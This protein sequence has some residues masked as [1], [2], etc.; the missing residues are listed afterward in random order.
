MRRFL[1]L[2]LAI[3]LIVAGGAYAGY[4]VY[5]ADMVR[6]GIDDWIAE[7]RARGLDIR[8]TNLDVGGFPLR[9]EAGAR[10]ITL[11]DGNR[12]VWQSAALTASAR[13]WRLTRIA[14]TLDGRQSL[15][16]AGDFPLR[17]TAAAGSG[18][19]RL[20]GNGGI[21]AG[22]LALSEPALRLPINVGLLRA[23]GLDLR[24]S[25]ATGD[26][27]GGTIAAGGDAWRLTLP[28]SP[29][30]ALGTLVEQAGA[31]VVV[32]GPVPAAPHRSAL[33]AWRDD[34]GTVEIERL[35]LR[36]GPVSVEATGTV[37]LDAALQPRGTLNARIQGFLEA[38][39]ALVEAGIV[40]A[41][42]AGLVKAGLTLLAGAPGPDGVA[43]LTA[44]LALENRRLFLG[45]IQ[46]G[47]IQPIVW[48]R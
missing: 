27:P 35:T 48:P 26:R 33:A 31:D 38:V 18:E 24:I 34:G 44:P 47:E 28:M 45:P 13:P 4:W 32:T 5:A 39:D 7:Q 21:A 37:T 10:A 9:L 16:V 20:A 43:T 29:L 11:A 15:S 19:I 17:L 36:W 42:D 46:L 8:T 40:A 1:P 30:P 25:E 41:K 23:D 22:S 2:L 6:V 3:L 14:Y 12:L